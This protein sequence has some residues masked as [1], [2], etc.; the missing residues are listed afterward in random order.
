ME[1]MPEAP[2]GMRE[3][4]R[5]QQEAPLPVSSLFKILLNVKWANEAF[6]DNSDDFGTSALLV[7]TDRR[8]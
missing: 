7:Y 4:Q 8:S 6:D 3:S 5:A 2:R 1:D